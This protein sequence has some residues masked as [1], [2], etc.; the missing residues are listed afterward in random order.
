MKALSVRQPWAWLI[1][2]RHK[3]IEN[4]SWKTGYR[5]DLLIHAS[6]GMTKDEYAEALSLCNK[7]GVELP[8]FSALE[9]GGV[10][11]RVTVTGCVDESDS[12]WFSGK[13]GWEMSEA[14]PLPFMPCKGRLSLFDIDYQVN[15]NV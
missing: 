6:Q 7:L 2:H 12:P 13:Y 4:R 15:T 1:V 9:R 14:T 8:E 11:G 3:P 5:G 10:V